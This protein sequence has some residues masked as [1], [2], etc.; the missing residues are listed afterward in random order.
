MNLIKRM[1]I[2]LALLPA[3]LGLAQTGAVST[4]SAVADRILMVDASSMP[5][6]G[7]KATL[8]VGP[9]RRTNDVY[10]GN[11]KLKVFPY[12]FK[13]NSGRLAIMVSDEAVAD[14]SAGK[15]IAV[16]GTATTSNRSGRILHIDATATPVDINHGALKL[17]F[18][19]GDRKMIFQPAYHLADQ[20]TVADSTPAINTNLAP[21][22]S[23]VGLHKP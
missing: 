17:W 8:T 12:F 23:L 3:G 14:I 21:T 19:V 6:A 10:T 5:V 9:L 15:A 20:A 7:G 2:L 1:L 13:N 4:N 22:G 18:M 16:I 11:Y